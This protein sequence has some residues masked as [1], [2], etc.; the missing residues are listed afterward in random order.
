VETGQPIARHT[1]VEVVLEVVRARARP[2]PGDLRRISVHVHVAARLPRAAEPVA[3]R[4]VPTRSSRDSSSTCSGWGWR[5]HGAHKR[6][7]L[8]SGPCKSRGGGPRCSQRDDRNSFEDCAPTTGAAAILWRPSVRRLDGVLAP[9]ST[10][11]AAV[12]KYGRDE[13]TA[14]PA[15]APEK[16]NKKKRS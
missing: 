5:R 11:R 4:R 13:T 3:A 10:W 14:P 7:H 8:G 2:A 15:P 1:G 16:R 6:R 12:V 9:H